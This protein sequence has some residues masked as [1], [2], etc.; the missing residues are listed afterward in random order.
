MLVASFGTSTPYAYWGFSVVGYVLDALHGAHQRIHC[1]N[2]AQLNQEWENREGRAVLVTTDRPDIALSRLLTTVDIPRLAFIDE[3][4]DAIAVTVLVYNMNMHEAIRFT[5]GYFC[6]LGAALLGNDI[7]IFGGQYLS[8][9]ARQFIEDVIREVVGESDEVVLGAVLARI[10][11]EGG[12][13]AEM[14]VS[15][16]L[17]RQMGVALLAS[18][19]RIHLSQEDQVLA[20][21]MADKY[22]PVFEQ[23]YL[24]C[25]RWPRELFFS[26]NR[27]KGHPGD[28]ELVGP[29]RC[30][31]WGPYLC[32][33]VG[34]WRATIE[35]ELIG[36]LSRNEFEA[37]VCIALQVVA[38]GRCVFPILGF[39]QFKLDFFVS[40]PN[41]AIEVRIHLLK[42]A[43]EGK[44]G[45]RG[46][47][48]RRL[49]TLGEAAQPPNFGG[50]RQC[51]SNFSP[52]Y[53]G[54][55]RS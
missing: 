9:T 5:T 50:D 34:R 52:K 37:D 7:K 14:K 27:L 24:D 35:V 3:A 40:N 42:G 51:L 44:F 4:E 20:R 16:L 17:A 2:I 10:A 41:A 18:T 32:L 43:I 31:V 46:V 49:A 29:A 26:S 55:I 25:M 45:L 6:C 38:S 47:E 39:F 28:I 19:P 30:L 12:A 1:I 8:C 53:S 11:P 13:I 23:R 48:V 54:S 36:N 33:P 22:R 15:E 21:S